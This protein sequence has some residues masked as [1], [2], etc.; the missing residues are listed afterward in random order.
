[1]NGRIWDKMRCIV[2]QSPAWCVEILR[3]VRCRFRS[4]W[5]ARR[6]RCSWHTGRT[7]RSRIGRSRGWSD[8][9]RTRSG[10]VLLGQLRAWGLRP[11]LRSRHGRSRLSE[12]G[13]RNH[14]RG[15]GCGNESAHGQIPPSYCCSNNGTGTARFR[16]ASSCSVFS[17]SCRL[18]ERHPSH[19]AQCPLR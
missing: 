1:M 3:N 15:R 17:S 11:W 2:P 10:S 5:C 18:L 7:R 16:S 12:S 19:A 9:C 8:R 4:L 6:V 13:S 14:N